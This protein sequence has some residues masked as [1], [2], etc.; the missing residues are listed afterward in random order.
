M[1]ERAVVW[2]N[3][4]HSS[5]F[6]QAFITLNVDENFFNTKNLQFVALSTVHFNFSNARNNNESAALMEK[7][8]INWQNMRFFTLLYGEIHN[9]LFNDML[10]NIGRYMTNLVVLVLARTTASYWPQELCNLKSTLRYLQVWLHDI[11]SIDDC[12]SQFTKLEIFQWS[13]GTTNYVPLKNLFNLPSIRVI[14]LDSENLEWNF[15]ISELYTTS[16]NSNDHRF[17]G[18][19]YNS[20]KNIYLQRNPVCDVYWSNVN[21]RSNSTIYDEYY[22]LF[23]LIDR[24]D[25]CEIKCSDN[26]YWICPPYSN[27]NGACDASCNAPSCGYDSGDCNQLCDFGICDIDSWGDSICDESCNSQECAW[28]G[29]DCL[30]DSNS[31]DIDYDTILCSINCT[32]IEGLKNGICETFCLDANFTECMEIEYA[33]DCMECLPEGAFNCWGY[34]FIFT[35]ISTSDIDGQDDL[36]QGDEWCLQEAY[37]DIVQDLTMN[38]NLTCDDVLGNPEYD[39]NANGEMGFHE[40]LAMFSPGVPKWQLDGTDCSFCVENI[41]A[42]YL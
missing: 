13:I 8:M 17:V 38:N 29:N 31:T 34:D 37:W 19:N 15:M 20:I 5:C 4:L 22:E 28:D 16:N 24:Y 35:I 40:F 26:T 30:Y 36:I 32:F 12:F 14:A 27:G 25:A 39:L 10:R 23:D 11:N 6:S 1:L 7:Y 21:N 9:G 2:L 3:D 41:S 33:N 18:Y 42:Y